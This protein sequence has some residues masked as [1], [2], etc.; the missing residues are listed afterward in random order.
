MT[1]GMERRKWYGRK[2]KLVAKK[3][4]QLL[5]DLWKYHATKE[6]VEGLNFTGNSSQEILNLATSFAVRVGRVI[7]AE[8]DQIIFSHPQAPSVTMSKRLPVYLNILKN[9]TFVKLIE[10]SDQAVMPVRR[11]V[12]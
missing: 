2:A 12:A 11:P 5:A 8:I 4:H 7:R 9:P 3:V 6:R 1:S 10:A